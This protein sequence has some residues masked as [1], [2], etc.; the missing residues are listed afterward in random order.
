[1]WR[2]VEETDRL[3]WVIAG[4]TSV[5]ILL[6]APAGGVALAGWLTSVARSGPD[7][8]RCAWVYG[9]ALVGF[10]AAQT[11]NTNAW[12]RYLEPMF[13][14]TMALMAA[15]AGWPRGRWSARLAWVGVLALAGLGAALTAYT[16]WSEPVVVK[17]W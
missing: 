9:L 1:L 8:R 12:Q 2:L 14:M 3:G 11:A 7:G 6:L 16:L 15:Q 10:V 17:T 4:R 13:L 5:V